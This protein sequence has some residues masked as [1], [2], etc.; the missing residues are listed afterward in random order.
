MCPCDGKSQLQFACLS[1]SRDPLADICWAILER[2]VVLFAALQK[3]DPVLIHEG[4]ISQVQDDA[5]TVGLFAD[6]RFQ[7]AY[8]FCVHS[9]AQLDDHLSVRRPRDLQQSPS[10]ENSYV[11]SAA[12][13][14]NGN[15][16]ANLKLLKLGS[17]TGI[18]VANFRNVCEIS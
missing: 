10:P 14:C 8:V 4:Q 6:Q 1:S 7:L 13:P 16:S 9:T 5:A 17:L 18:Q 12:H 11:R 2:D 15:H 3:I